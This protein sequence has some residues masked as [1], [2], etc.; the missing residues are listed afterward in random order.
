MSDVR[1][2]NSIAELLEAFGSIK[3]F[4]GHISGVPWQGWF[5]LEISPLPSF[6]TR[7]NVVADIINNQFVTVSEGRVY[8]S[9]NCSSVYHEL[10]ERFK[11]ALETVEDITFKVAVYKGHPELLGG[12]PVAVALEPAITYSE[13]SDHPHINTCQITKIGGRE[14]F[15]PDS[16]CYIENPAD[17]GDNE[18]MRLLN[19]FDEIVIWM[20]RHQI[21]L[22]TRK[23]KIPG[24][25][26]GRAAPRDDRFMAVRLNPDGPCRCGKRVTYR[27]CHMPADVTAIEKCSRQKAVEIIE[28]YIIPARKWEINFETPQQVMMKKLR[29]FLLQP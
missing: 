7:Q 16:I 6:K 10:P 5:L 21:W 18:Y 26:I 14:C 19:A 11:K 20:L 9:E 8:H 12:Q 29:D 4:E 24:L 2:I 23:Q 25:W 27:S 17:L 15:M 3:W 22:E 28:R 1:Q 13:Y